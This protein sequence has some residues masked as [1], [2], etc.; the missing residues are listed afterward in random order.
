MFQKKKPAVVKKVESEDE[1]AEEQEEED[2]SKATTELKTESAVDSDNEQKPKNINDIGLD[3]SPDK[4][5]PEPM[6][7]KSDKKTEVENF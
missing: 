3:I 2:E 5:Q 1:E 7:P 6:A 4:K